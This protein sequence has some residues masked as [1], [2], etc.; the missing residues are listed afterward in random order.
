M[1]SKIRSSF[2]KP[3][4]QQSVVQK[5]SIDPRFSSSYGEFDP[6]VCEVEHLKKI[7]K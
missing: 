3:K 7:Q 5:K 6:I 1:S 4:T 2:Q